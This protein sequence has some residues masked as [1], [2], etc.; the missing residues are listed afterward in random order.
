M[1]TRRGTSICELAQH[2]LIYKS[3]C[4]GI[5]IYMYTCDHMNVC[6][7]VLSASTRKGTDICEFAQHGFIYKG[8]C[9]MT[10]VCL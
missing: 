6:K 9:D 8:I 4:D 7:E 3:I 10:Y 1:R 2:E 5:Y